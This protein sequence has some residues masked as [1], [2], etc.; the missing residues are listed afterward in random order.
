MASIDLK[1]PKKMILREFML[2]SI[3]ANEVLDGSEIGLME[4][5][6]TIVENENGIQTSFA[7]SVD[8]KNE[9][10]T[11]V[12]LHEPKI[13]DVD[14]YPDQHIAALSGKYLIQ[15]LEAKALSSLRRIQ[16]ISVRIPGGQIPIGVR[17]YGSFADK[18]FDGA[19]IYPN[20][21]PSMTALEWANSLYE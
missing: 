20:D 17:I 15:A 7:A 5:F 18:N 16:A 21:N 2:F 3:G 13:P 4:I 10:K 14:K 1:T 6:G 12:P 9:T 19:L 11:I 8:N